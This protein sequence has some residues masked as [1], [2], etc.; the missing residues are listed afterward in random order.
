M[1]PP[2]DGSATPAA[3][4]ELSLANA[5]FVTGRL[6]FGGDLSPRFVDARAQLDEL[7]AAGI[8]HVAD[9]RDE[10]SDEELV[11]TWHPELRYLYHPV[12]DAGQHIPADW[13]EGLNAWVDEALADPFARVLV[14]CHMGVNRAP[15]AAFGLL[16]AQ[17]ARVPEALT[18]I[19]AARPVAVI[20]YADD[21]LS[22]YLARSKADRNTRSGARRSLKRWRRAH[23]IDQSAVIRQIRSG[24]GGGS[25]WAIRINR[26]SI[27]ELQQL[28][29]PD[30]VAVLGFEISVVPDELAQRDEVLLWLDGP[31]GGVVGAGLVAGPP[32]PSGAPADGPGLILPVGLASF[33]PTALVPDA[34]IR[35]LIPAEASFPGDA[36]NPVLLGTEAVGVLR[37]ALQVVAW[38][39][40][41][42]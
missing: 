31:G 3:L 36:P 26:A 4:P 40:R 20:D 24:E 41:G 29:K 32:Q 1:K 30:R 10:W 27:R 23:R 19:R 21:A 15:S 12:R 2:R 5:N 14:H 33:E 38:A 17:G 42:H 34:V 11:A 16:L 6:A 22:W 9:L 35:A 18:A 25:L 13:F 7:V 37:R 39:A 28:W 8:T